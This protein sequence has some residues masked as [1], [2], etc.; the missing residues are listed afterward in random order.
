MLQCAKL[1]VD[2]LLY[3]TRHLLRNSNDVWESYA[4]SP[5]KVMRALK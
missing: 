4:L 2:G 1:I 3:V 5:R